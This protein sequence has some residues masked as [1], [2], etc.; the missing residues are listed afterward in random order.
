MDQSEEMDNVDAPVKR[1]RGHRHG[2][3]VSGSER[4]RH[5]LAKHPGRRRIHH[6]FHRR[7]DDG[8][9]RRRRAA[10]EPELRES[11]RARRRNRSVRRRVLRLQ[12]PR[13][14]ADGSAAASLPAVRL[15]S[16]R[17][18]RLRSALVSRPGRRLRRVDRQLLPEPVV[19]EFRAAQRRR[20]LDRDRQRTAISHD[21][22]L[23]QA[24]SQGTELS[25]CRRPAR[26]RSSPSTS[27]AR[28][29]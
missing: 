15:G 11:A 27:P 28:G 1:S 14:V 8:G 9:G 10:Q 29:C 24:R 22:R 26:P 18:C 4:S 19:R 6:V 23:V 17:G 5:V 12:Q 2:R 16:A 13:R 25:R 21:A 20:S 3:S 7:T